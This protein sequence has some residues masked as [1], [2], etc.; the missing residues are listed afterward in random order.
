MPPRVIRL[1]PDDRAKGVPPHWM[2]YIQV[3]S[4]DDAAAK[5][6]KLGAKVLAPAFDVM[7]VGRMAVLQDPTG[8]IF[9]AGNRRS[10]AASVSPAFRARY[11]GPI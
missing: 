9:V 4:A 6:E 11:A 3:D 5:A 8:A 2:L 10:I 1:R 7:D